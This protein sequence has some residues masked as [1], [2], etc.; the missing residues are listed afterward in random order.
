M[1]ENILS[2]GACV[3]V[4]YDDLKRGLNGVYIHTNCSGK[5]FCTLHIEM[6]YI[7]YYLGFARVLSRTSL[8]LYMF[9]AFIQIY[10]HGTKKT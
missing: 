5:L 9:G 1:A 3:M 4:R 2:I 7:D 10:F 8:N 6:S